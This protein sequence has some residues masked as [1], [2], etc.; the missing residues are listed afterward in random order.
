MGGL[1]TYHTS[2]PQPWAVDRINKQVNEQKHSNLEGKEIPTN[3]T[4]KQKR[5]EL[6][7]RKEI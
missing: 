4:E 7:E 1:M 5:A 3:E 6:R 2:S